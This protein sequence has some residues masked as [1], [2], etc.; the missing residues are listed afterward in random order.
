[1]ANTTTGWLHIRERMHSS[2]DRSQSGSPSPPPP[3]YGCCGAAPIAIVRIGLRALT[4]RGEPFLP[5][6]RACPASDAT[7]APQ[8]PLRLDAPL[9][10]RGLGHAEQHGEGGR[11]QDEREAGG[12]SV[13]IALPPPRGGGGIGRGGGRTDGD[14]PARGEGAPSWSRDHHGQRVCGLADR[15]IN[16]TDAK[17]ENGRIGGGARAPHCETFFSPEINILFN[18]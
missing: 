4:C 6:P 9:G 8:P 7:A 12:G 11:G 16:A 1:M 10:G 17:A 15:A 13:G 2:V 3:P 18:S 5:L 14:A